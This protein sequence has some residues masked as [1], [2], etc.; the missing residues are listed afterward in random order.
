[1]AIDFVYFA[2]LNL[3]GSAS[4]KQQTD[5][6][7]IPNIS[8]L[9]RRKRLRFAVQQFVITLVI[10]GVMVALHLNPLWRL[11]LQLLFSA[12]TVSYFQARDKT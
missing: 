4:Q 8:L 3:K 7:C 12:A 11:F 1:M 5:E 6:V 10:L 2:D 9:E